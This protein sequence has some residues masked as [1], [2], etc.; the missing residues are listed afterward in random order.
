[1][2]QIVA[3]VMDIPVEK[4]YIPEVDTSM[5]PFDSAGTQASRVTYVCGKGTYETAVKLKNLLISSFSEIKG[6]SCEN[7][8]L[9]NGYLLIDGKPECKYEEAVIEIQ[10]KLNMDISETHKYKAKANPAVYAVNFAE[11]EIDKL[12]GLVKVTDVLAVHDIGQAINRGFVEGQIQ[13][14]IQMGIGYALSEEIE[15]DEKGNVKSDTFA[16]Y[17]VVNMPDMP[18]VKVLLVEEPDPNGPFGAK[19]VGEISTCAM[20]PAVIN[21]IEHG[22]GIEIDK[23]PATPERILKA[24]NDF[25]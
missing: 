23:L 10:N 14:A 18:R 11:V 3:E 21:A 17:H 2:A 12:T 6:V 25:F 7:V 20:A 8:S 15:V 19:S 5:S 1:M 9:S 22:L 4:I 16:K 24:M 13:G